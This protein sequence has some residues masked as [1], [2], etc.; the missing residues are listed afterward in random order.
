MRRG[1]WED[2]LAGVLVAPEVLTGNC[3]Y[4]SD[5]NILRGIFLNHVTQPL[6]PP[7]RAENLLGFL[8][9]EGNGFL[10]RWPFEKSI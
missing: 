3:A 9:H 10:R 1:P 6:P 4:A 8:F 2:W 7:R 5:G